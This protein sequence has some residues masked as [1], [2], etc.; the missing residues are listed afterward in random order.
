LKTEAY[1]IRRLAV[2]EVKKPD[3]PPVLIYKGQGFTWRGSTGA[4]FYVMERAESI[5]GPW[6]IIA[7]GLEDSVI[8][9]V[10]NFEGTPEASEPLILYYDETRESG[11]TYYY[12][13]KGENTVGSSGYSN[14][15]KI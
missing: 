11:K 15:L 8:A 7:A 3:F 14:I 13:I 9:D 1:K 2:P 10:S 5:N 4:A 6:K 12:R